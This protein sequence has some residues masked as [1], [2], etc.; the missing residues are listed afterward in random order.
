MV[1][2]SQNWNMLFDMEI[3]NVFVGSKSCPRLGDERVTPNIYSY[4]YMRPVAGALDAESRKV[5]EKKFG[6]LFVTK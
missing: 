1:V 3:Q 5:K 4:I 6:K 2:G